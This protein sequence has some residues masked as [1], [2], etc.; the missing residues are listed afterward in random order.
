MNCTRV[1]GV[2]GPS[3]TCNSLHAYNT[4]NVTINVVTTGTNIPLPEYQIIDT[5][6]VNKDN[7]H[8]KDFYDKSFIKGVEGMQGIILAGGSGT[9]LYPLT[10]SISKYLLPIYEETLVKSTILV[11]I[12]KEQTLILSI[13]F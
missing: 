6:I 9:R 12:M 3:V 1:Q 10:R 11:A 2:T 13:I 5:F 4:N 7:T 8:K